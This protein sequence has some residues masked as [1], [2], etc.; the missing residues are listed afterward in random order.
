MKKYEILRILDRETRVLKI[1]GKYSNWV[2]RIIDGDN[3]TKRIR[4]GEQLCLF[5]ADLED[6]LSF[7]I[8][9]STVKDWGYVFDDT[10]WIETR[11]SI[12]YLKELPV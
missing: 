11:N 8:R 4:I 6:F 1:E 10:I 5:Y 9:T 12:Y 7:G 3:L 2:G